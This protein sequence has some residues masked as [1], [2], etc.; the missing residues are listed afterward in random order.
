VVKERQNGVDF[1]DA[2]GT[3]AGSVVA[4]AVGVERLDLH[5]DI[6]SR[7]LGEMGSDAAEETVRRRTFG[8]G[9]IFPAKA[10]GVS[11]VTHPCYLVQ[12]PPWIINIGE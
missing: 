6:A 12:G 5:V 9:S 11:F 4:S 1:D 2:V 8:G 3:A 7:P 10:R